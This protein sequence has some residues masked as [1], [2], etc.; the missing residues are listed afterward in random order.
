M[1]QD[2]FY[3]SDK[4]SQDSYRTNEDPF[5][6]TVRNSNSVL[7]QSDIKNSV[8]KS[9]CCAGQIM[10]CVDHFCISL[11]ENIKKLDNR[12]QAKLKVEIMQLMYKAEFDTEF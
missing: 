12:K 8:I 5:G 6:A 7:K 10:D 11:A 1:E 3:D 9:S 4:I 2:M